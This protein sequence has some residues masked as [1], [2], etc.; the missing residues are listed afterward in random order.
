MI[1]LFTLNGDPRAVTPIT[2]TAG[3]ISLTISRP[4]ARWST[5]PPKIF[6]GSIECAVY[7][8]LSDLLRPHDCADMQAVLARR[9]GTQCV[10]EENPIITGSVGRSGTI[11]LTSM[12]GKLQ[13][14]TMQD[15]L[16]HYPNNHA[17]LVRKTPELPR[18][19][20]NYAL[21]PGPGPLI[22]T[23]DAVAELWWPDRETAIRSWSSPAVQMEQAEDCTRFIG[24]GETLFGDELYIVG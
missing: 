10:A 17:P 7:E 1:K 11:K 15:F 18:Y 6:S 19:N 13:A 24:S 9:P 2:P 3:V 5:M 23:F 22:N 8:T 21:S 16:H 4:V 20:Q 12:F 14:M